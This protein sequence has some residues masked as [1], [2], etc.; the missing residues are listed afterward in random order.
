MLTLKLLAL[1]TRYGNH[2][3]LSTQLVKPNNQIRDGLVS[4]ITSSNWLCLYIINI[5]KNL[6]LSIAKRQQ[7]ALSY[8]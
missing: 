2:F 3:P 1:A 6:Q 8:S 7:N 5:Q 4:G